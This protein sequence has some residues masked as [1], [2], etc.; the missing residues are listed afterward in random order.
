VNAGHPD[1][2]DGEFGSRKESI[3]QD[4][5]DNGEQIDPNGYHRKENVLS[6]F[7]MILRSK[8]RNALIIHQDRSLD[9][10]RKE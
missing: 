3:D 4:Q 9:N 6:K 2:N 10:K 7:G 8:Q 1:G 5:D